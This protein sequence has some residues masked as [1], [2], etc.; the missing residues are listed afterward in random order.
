MRGSVQPCIRDYGTD[1]AIH[2]LDQPD[3]P[4]ELV[5][6]QDAESYAFESN[7]LLQLHLCTKKGLALRML[8]GRDTIAQPS[9]CSSSCPEIYKMPCIPTC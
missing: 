3:L 9:F 8:A 1:L 2:Q 7:P 6:L 5:H 4:T